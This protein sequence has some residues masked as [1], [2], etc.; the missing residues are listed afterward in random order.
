MKVLITG[1]A[2]R[3]GRRVAR[4]LLEDHEVVGLDTSA[5]PG[6]PREITL[7]RADLRK[8]STDDVLRREQPEAVV[9]L[10]SLRHVFDERLR[11][12]VNV[13]GTR[14]LLDLCAKHGVRRLVVLS[15]S[16]VYGALPE[17]PFY[18]AEDTGLSVSRHYP[19]IRDLAEL[20]TLASGFLWHY[21]EVATAILR[22]ASVL[23]KR[24]PSTMSGYLQLEVSPTVMGFDPMMQFIDEEDLARA[25]VR[26]VEQKARG[27][28]NVTGGAALPLHSAIRIAGGRAL[29]LP[30]PL[31]R[32]LIGMMFR[33]GFAPAPSDAVD[34]LKYP[35]T[36]DGR[37]FREATGFVAEHDLLQSLRS[38]RG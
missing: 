26:C 3:L 8:K 25:I 13:G 18:M 7:H 20:D 15:S 22:P 23:G 4:R 10:A 14:K 6:R 38:V 28:F 19:E 21:P 11:H 31:C 16:Y 35:C 36:I 5:W 2:G 30:E 12:D 29:P 34:F 32:A 24:S 33:L 9:H 1:A 37:A 17:N 27:V